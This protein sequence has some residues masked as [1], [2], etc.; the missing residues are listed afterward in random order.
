[1]LLQYGTMSDIVKLTDLILI[2]SN[3]LKYGF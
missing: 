1:M 3:T 2:Y